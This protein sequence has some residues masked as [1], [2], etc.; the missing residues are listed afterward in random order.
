MSIEWALTVTRRYLTYTG[1]GTGSN[2]KNTRAGWLANVLQTGEYPHAC[3]NHWK[4]E[5]SQSLTPN[6]AKAKTIRKA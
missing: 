2:A 3:K 1:T 5:C 6:N 4:K